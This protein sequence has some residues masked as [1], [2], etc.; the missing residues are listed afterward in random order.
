MINEALSINPQAQWRDP[1]SEELSP[2]ELPPFVAPSTS[3]IEGLKKHL[4]YELWLYLQGADALGID[5]ERHLIERKAAAHLT[6]VMLLVTSGLEEV[7]MNAPVVQ[8]RIRW[9]QL[10]VLNRINKQAYARPYYELAAESIIRQA[11]QQKAN[12]SLWQALP[13]NEQEAALRKRWGNLPSEELIAREQKAHNDYHAQRAIIIAPYTGWDLEI[14]HPSFGP[15]LVKELIRRSLLEVEAYLTVGW[16]VVYSVESPRPGDLRHAITPEQ[17]PHILTI[18]KMAIANSSTAERLILKKAKKWFE[19]Q[20]QDIIDSNK[21]DVIDSNKTAINHQPQK[22]TM[23]Q[24]ALIHTYETGLSMTRVKAA[25]L[26]EKYNYTSAESLYIESLT[27]S[28]TTDRLGV[29]GTS[30]TNMIK[31]IKGILPALSAPARQRAENE[32]SILEAKK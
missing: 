10:R 16:V 24:I 6:R 26:V 18:L 22:F 28:R 21:Q 3:A 2:L 31:R 12:D 15:W 25:A 29:E 27:M 11:R 5:Y 30:L 14:E 19:K 7:P 1:S 8:A 4:H 13:P 9:V 20:G 23:K 17:L 32:L